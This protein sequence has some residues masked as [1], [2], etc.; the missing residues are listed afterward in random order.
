MLRWVDRRGRYDLPNIP[1]K[2]LSVESLESKRI[3]LTANCVQEDMLAFFHRGNQL[4]YLCSLDS[5]K[6]GIHAVTIGSGTPKQIARLP[7]GLHSRFAWTADNRRLISSPEPERRERIEL[8]ND[9]KV[10]ISTM[11]LPSRTKR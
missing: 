7:S 1:G 5:P 4:A 2:L 9:K 10:C 3:P 8:F 6:T 11:Q